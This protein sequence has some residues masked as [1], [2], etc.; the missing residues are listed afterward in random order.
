MSHKKVKVNNLPQ[1]PFAMEEAFSRLRINVGFTGSDV[2]K[3]LVIS[4]LPDEGKSFVSMQ[5]WHQMA[6]M[7]T[8][9]VLV[10]MDLRNSVMVEKYDIRSEGPGKI[11]GTSQ[12]LSGDYPLEEA[13]LHTDINGGDIIPN[14]DNI[15]NPAIL[16]ESARC[17]QMLD[18]LA[19]KYRYVFVDAPA[20]ELVSDGERLASMCDG[21]IFVVRSSSTSK[22][23]V[24]NSIQQLQ[25]SG[26][27][28]LG[29]VLNRTES[30][31]TAYYHK[32]GKYGQYGYYGDGYYGK[33]K[34]AR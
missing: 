26:C 17:R 20:L 19:A 4:S 12:Y 1:F 8:P 13:I 27:P 11:C 24:H 9:S 6:S 7:G 29:I 34:E 5:L 14:T 33:G 16:V 10:D 15:V 21:A 28:I 31:K 18:G 30:S 32:Y 2:K 3:V 23:T 25:R 22:R